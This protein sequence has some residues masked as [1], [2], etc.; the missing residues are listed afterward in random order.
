MKHRACLIWLIIILFDFELMATQRQVELHQDYL[1]T[2]DGLP[3][4]TVRDILQDS[5]GFIWFGTLNGMG[6][7][8]GYNLKNCSNVPWSEFPISDMRVKHIKESS[9]GLLWV[10]SSGDKISCYDPERNEFLDYTGQDR[11]LDSYRN[12]SLFGDEVWLWG[13]Q[14]CLY[15]KY[16]DGMFNSVRFDCDNGKLKSNLV[17]FLSRTSDGTIWIATG[18]GVCKVQDGKTSVIGGN[19][20]YQYIAIHD[21]TPYF[22]A[23]DGSVSKYDKASGE[24]KRQARVPGVSRRNDL[25]GEIV[26]GDKWILFTTRGCYEFD[27]AKSM[28]HELPVGI[29]KGKTVDDGNGIYGIYDG[30]GNFHCYKKG[31]GFLK[32]FKAMTPE[33]V[34]LIDL[35]RYSILE[36]SRGIIWIT[37]RGNGLWAYLPEKER[38]EHFTTGDKENILP[39]DALLDIFE[40]KS[41]TLWIGTE[42]TGV[43]HCTV[44]KKS[45]KLFLPVARDT[46]GSESVRLV[47]KLTNGDM[48][49]GTRQGEFY[50]YDDR[51]EVLKSRQNVGFNI[52]DA[53]ADSLGHLWLASR[54]NG[55]VINDKIYKNNG[56]DSTSL[57]LN[58]LFS[59]LKDRKGRMWIGTLGKGL[60]LAYR[61]NDGTLAFRHFLTQTYGMRR[62]KAL[63][64]DRNGYIWAATSDGVIV[65]N[66]DSLIADANK[67]HHYSKEKG[68]LHETDLRSLF[69]DSHGRMW[70]GENG[71]GVC[72]IEIR[73]KNYA[74]PICQHYSTDN[75]LVNGNVQS[76]I[77]DRNGHIWLST[78]YG[79][80]CFETANKSF[81]SFF[82]SN[83]HLG[84]VYSENSTA[85][86]SDGRL[87][88]GGYKGVLI[89]NP[90]QVLGNQLP[91][92]V[93]FTELHVN[94]LPANPGISDNKQ[95][96]SISYC[97]RIEQ[98]YNQNTLEI[99][100][101]T[102]G[103][104][105]I[106]PRYCYK[107][108]GIDESWSKPSNLNFASYR[109]LLPGDYTLHVKACNADGVWGDE[110]TIAIVVKPP[111]WQTWWARIIYI[112][113]IAGGCFLL[114][115]TLRHIDSLRNKVSMER[116]LTDY[117]LD[118]FTNI[119]HEFR[120]PL[121]LIGIALEKLR[122][123]PDMSLDIRSS[124]DVL[125]RSS[126]R[127]S[128]LID[129][130][131]TF[132]KV[133]KNK[134]RLHPEPTDIK[135]FSEELF[136]G[137]KDAAAARGISYTFD[138]SQE[139][140]MVN[141]DRDSLEK[142][143]VNLIS[144][145]IKY[146]PSEGSVKVSLDCHVSPSGI[147]L[148][149]SDTGVGIPKEKQKELF[150]QF[151]QT[152]FSRSSMGIGLHLTHSL[153]KLNGGNI[154]YQDNPGGGSVFT[155]TL[156]ANEVA[157]VD[158]A[159]SVTDA[160]IMQPISDMEVQEDMP[161]ESGQGRAC[162]PSARRVLIIEDDM[163]VRE[164]LRNEFGRDYDV[165]TAAD[166]KIGLETA[167]N[168]EFDLVICDVMMPVMDGMEVTRQLKE[169]FDTS[170]V[171]VILLTALADDEH[172]L[173]GI[174]A[175]ADA[176]V[177]K[178]FSIKYLKTRVER[179]IAQR[180]KL[181][182]KFSAS[183]TMKMPAFVGNN[184]DRAFVEKLNKIIDA[185]MVNSEF[186]VDDFASDMALGRTSFFRKVKGVTGYAPK[187]YL[188]I[189]R[190]KRAAELLVATD[191]TVNEVA[192]KVGIPAPSSF[193]KCFKE[194][195]GTSP[196]A[197]RRENTT[198]TTSPSDIVT[199]NLQVLPSDVSSKSEDMS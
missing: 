154:Q 147:I 157:S 46:N 19:T 161:Q 74:H 45:E 126:R 69:E 193:N 84:N 27:F 110:T 49:I 48:V 42:L 15:V 47:K 172:R 56:K 151:M 140:I 36:D 170:H 23:D 90:V 195:F 24:L 187:E 141:V 78:E 62:V 65:F 146:T 138:C 159:T 132:R 26:D 127:M 156:P 114:F 191:M 163:D 179:L 109:N 71:S 136:D 79:I 188:R 50:V 108:D 194:Q 171:P 63:T 104:S 122:D 166:G 91:P 117:K 197:Y 98:A 94:G 10:A 131:L 60:D 112:L 133:E 162:A 93:T 160:A 31:K 150:S 95:W 80:S 135:V 105:S 18:Q 168:D 107:L 149:V 176:Y 72:V 58:A 101:S 86:L 43:V 134:Y 139:G 52:Y 174:E 76:I 7:Y 137:F 21:N 144:N 16:A 198:V 29:S 59:I 64:E 53:A 129:Q 11:Y 61:R 100:F 12:I 75:G 158:T 199:D 115:S 111:F 116:Q 4:N 81:H 32:S 180:E 55:L 130:L 106:L 124:V 57:N 118:F 1:T 175:C 30:T 13:E 185:Q 142:I 2:R 165:V 17:T 181:M 20:L 145:A 183:P 190:M 178:P 99:Y 39:S 3:H 103:F 25:T 128:R 92:M 177:T 167:T 123:I 51:L 33:Q 73:D 192:F 9:D 85:L 121:T 88:F 70:V 5:R 96:K 182:D 189:V 184:K 119:S 14:G 153:V 6:R 196:T 22:I 38:L 143:M 66:P 186:S 40:D 125:D 34:K 28:L 152:S 113:L 44:M 155:V 54:N 68:L 41:G 164:L 83:D 8:D 67:Y 35:E 173:E 97:D 120:T 102:L 169:N 82:F 87:A 77:E 37:T 89:V 148:T